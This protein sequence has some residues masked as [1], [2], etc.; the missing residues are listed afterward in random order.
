MTGAGLNEKQRGWLVEFQRNNDSV[1][2]RRVAARVEGMTK[3]ERF[4][5]AKRFWRAPEPASKWKQGD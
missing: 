1:L 4:R 2:G 3:G 5:A